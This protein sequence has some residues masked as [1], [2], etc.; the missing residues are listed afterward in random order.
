MSETATDQFRDLRRAADGASRQLVN[1]VADACPGEHKTVQH[2]DGKSPW[3][4]ECGRTDRGHQIK[5]IKPEPSVAVQRCSLCGRERTIEDA[6]DY[7]PLQAM[8]G[9]PLGWY[10]GDDGE[11]CPEC[12]TKTLRGES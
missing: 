8:T 12:M 10:S 4:H 2:R 3:C 9:K 7:N 6:Y 1:A 11:V 5:V